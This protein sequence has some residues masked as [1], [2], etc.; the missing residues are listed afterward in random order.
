MKIHHYLSLL[1]IVPMSGIKKYIQENVRAD[2]VLKA[3][4]E[5]DKEGR[6]ILL[7][8]QSY[9]SCLTDTSGI[10]YSGN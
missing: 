8:W 4:T 6:I 3:R 2:Q 1:A 5:Q 7:V 9:I 10:I